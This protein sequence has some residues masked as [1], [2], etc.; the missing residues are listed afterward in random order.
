MQTIYDPHYNTH[1]KILHQD[2]HYNQTHNASFNHDYQN[3][4]YWSLKMFEHHN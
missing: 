4:K 1:M 2:L 3:L